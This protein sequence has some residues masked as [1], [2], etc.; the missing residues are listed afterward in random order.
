[1]QKWQRRLNWLQKRVAG[2]CH[3]DRDIRA[4][5]GAV[6]FSSMNIDEFYLEKT[7][8]I[9]GYMYRGVAIK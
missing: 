8:R 1:V 3:L 5:V 6:P 9:H 4:L 2:G 7:P